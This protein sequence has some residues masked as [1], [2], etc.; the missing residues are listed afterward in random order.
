MKYYTQARTSGGFADFT[1]DNL[2]GIKKIL[3][4][5]RNAFDT[6][7]ILTYI[8]NKTGGC[9]EILTPGYEALKC[10]LVL[11]DKGVA[12]IC[13]NTSDIKDEKHTLMYECFGEA[14]K[15]HDEWEKI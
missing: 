10:G 6:D 1:P 3:L 13:E 15:I 12:V 9:E 11:R 5:K 14:K 2:Q 8:Q 7:L 4:D